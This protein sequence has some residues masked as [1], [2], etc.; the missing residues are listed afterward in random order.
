MSP[1]RLLPLWNAWLFTSEW[2]S[3]A[4]LSKI[5]GYASADPKV[6]NGRAAAEA[7]RS[8][9]RTPYGSSDAANQSTRISWIS[10]RS[11][12][13]IFIALKLA[14]YVIRTCRFVPRWLQKRNNEGS[15]C[16]SMIIM[17]NGQHRGSRELERAS[18]PSG[19]LLPILMNSNY[20]SEP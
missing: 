15:A 7:S 12:G 11:S 6:W 5:V 19:G 4:A 10:I 1:T 3:A 18:S 9:S 13:L 17:Y 20:R 16:G 2:N 14:S 8:W